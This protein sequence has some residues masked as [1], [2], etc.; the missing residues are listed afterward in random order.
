MRRGGDPVAV[1]SKH[2]PGTFA[3]RL[4]LHGWNADNR[5][6]SDAY[7]ADRENV[8]ADSTEPDQLTTDRAPT[9][10]TGQDPARWLLKPG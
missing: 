10:T 9:T 8:G 2:D 7:A 3:L 5:R 6:A 4:R 1:S